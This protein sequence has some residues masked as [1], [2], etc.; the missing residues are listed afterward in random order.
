MAK[1]TIDIGHGSNT[2]PPDKGVWKNGKE[3]AEHDFNSKLALRI[4]ALLETNGHTVILGQ[5]PNKYDVPLSARTLLYKREKVDLVVSIHANANNDSNV[6]GRCVFYWHDSADSKRLAEA[7]RD[8]IKALD[9]SL[10]GNGLHASRV[11]DWTN[12]HITRVNTRDNGIPAVLVEHGFMTGNKDFDLIFGNKQTEYIED[13]A[14]ANVN[15]ILKYLGAKPVK[16]SVSKPQPKTE[17]PKT[18]VNKTLHLPKSAKTWRVYNVN[19]PYVTGKEIHLLT[20]SAFPNGITYDILEE[21]G[22]HVYVINTSVKGRVAI[23][24]H[25]NTGAIIKGSSTPVAK[26]KPK[27]KP[28]SSGSSYKEKGTFYPNDTIIVRDAPSTKSNIIARYYKGEKV[29]YHTVHLK[30]GYV[31][32]QYN[33]S[34]GRQGY[35]PCRTYNNGKYGTLWGTIK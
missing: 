9:Y 22:N 5:N 6:N 16:P 33:R 7:I 17:K 32:L 1:I 30:N 14:Q 13:M 4:K 28:Q 35:I 26:P 31:W 29:T 20:P 27:P 24:A 2:F 21:K 12:L 11:G 23:Y 15:G 18:K 25:P 8:E 19:G 3:Y 34:N 10:H